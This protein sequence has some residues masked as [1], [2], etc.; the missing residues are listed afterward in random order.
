[1]AKSK[2][3]NNNTLRDQF[4]FEAGLRVEDITIERY[5]GES[6][7]ESEDREIFTGD[8]KGN[9]RI[10]YPSLNNRFYSHRNPKNVLID[11]YRTRHAVPFLNK[12]G[13]LVKYTMEGKNQIFFPPEMID[14]YHDKR[15][16]SVLAVTEGEKKAFVG[17]KNGFDIV[18]I[19]GIWNFCSDD[20]VDSNKQKQLMPALVEF[21]KVCQVEIIVLL[22]DSDALSI[23]DKYSSYSDIKTATDR[24]NNFFKATERFAQLIFQEG[25]KFYHSYINPHISE[26]KLGLD[27]L[28]FLK[29]KN[30]SRDW[31][32]IEKGTIYGP[33]DSTLDIYNDFLESVSG[34]VFTSFFCTTKIQFIREVD[35]KHIFQLNDPIAF[36]NYHKKTL[37]PLKE[38]RFY[39]RLFEIN[40][41]GTIKEKE[42][43][44]RESIWI[45]GG[46][47][48]GYTQN[49][50]IKCISNFTM[51]VLFLLKSSTNPKR[52]I[53]LENIL[54]Q[55]SIKEFTMDDLVGVSA[56]RKKIISDGSFIYKGD[57]H[58]FLNLQEILFKN[59]N[60]ATELNS[61]G[62]QKNY[63]FYAWSNGITND[64]K[65][66]PTDEFGVLNYRNEKYYLPAFSSLYTNSDEGFEN[67]RKFKFVESPVTFEEWSKLFFATYKQNGAIAICF[68][69]ASLFWDIIFG[70]FRA[71]PMLNCFG[72]K[73]SGKS[74]LAKSLQY[75]FG[76]PQNA[77]SLENN[78]STKKGMYR[79]FSQFRNSIIMFEEY[80]NTID[81]FTIGLLKNLFDGIGYEK[82]QT[83]QDNKTMS[84]P[85][86]STAIICG[87]DM[88]T[89]DPALL[90][91]V[92]L[93]PFKDGQFSEADRLNKD[94]LSKLEQ[95]G[96]TSI[97]VKI[98]GHRNV[99]EAGFKDQYAK[100]AKK[101][102]D[103][104]KRTDLD[105]RVWKSSAMI[106][107]P[108]AVLVENKLIELPFSLDELFAKFVNMLKYH[109]EVATSNQETHVFWD[110]L[111]NLFE[112]GYISVEK[113][114]FK[115][116][117]QCVAL[118]ISKIWPLYAI[119]FRKEH[120][121]SGMDK[122]TLIN[123][124]KN[125]PAFTEE[126]KSVRFEHQ[127]SNALLFRVKDLPI[128]LVKLIKEPETDSAA[129]GPSTEK[130][131]E[132]SDIIEGPDKLPF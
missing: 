20:E 28:I 61:L 107:A 4:L 89:I 38:F 10:Y 21:I 79:K 56:F 131:E 50:Q 127:V 24:P 29:Q 95:K 83:S 9:M 68:G 109:R 85:V 90:S 117:E 5:V 92:L 27:D 18:G 26:N 74:T 57:M 75:L 43:H 6:F 32:D 40:A 66:Y 39:S 54:N 106:M 22:H 101:F 65:F 112:N 80:K 98:L 31:E 37:Q 87:Q 88:P 34:N 102:N 8:P 119:E 81:P 14:A 99:I 1:M 93:L 118:R 114:D 122:A 84:S 132:G 77:I 60:L 47:Y 97:T 96:L 33:V 41:D 25:V 46:K 55:K 7:S 13:E 3:N 30:Y 51:N 23:S 44:S 91:R 116:I 94:E 42:I 105:D 16:I 45:E 111:Q 123:Y 126:S 103:E 52:I 48:F 120:N 2:N 78:S 67:E 12:K 15:K 104:F 11:S 63:G 115:F 108:V 49:N 76:E 19:S 62:W 69:V 58:E 82:A 59:E 53:A 72:V 73:G 17:C 64:G 125:S 128:S 100:W 124:L 70:E 121:R 129:Q 35:L 113:G 86:Y 110:I 130:V 71:F 36:F